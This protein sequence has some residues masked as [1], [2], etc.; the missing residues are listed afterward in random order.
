MRKIK[1]YNGFLL[2]F[3]INLLFNAEWTILAFILLLLH[4]FIKLPL[5]PFFAALGLWIGY[6]FITTLIIYLL[7]RSASS[8]KTPRRQN[9]NPYS[10]TNYPANISQMH[11]PNPKNIEKKRQAENISI[12]RKESEISLPISNVEAGRDAV[13]KIKPDEMKSELARAIMTYPS[14]TKSDS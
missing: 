9:K 8:S 12:R 11:A 13:S 2:S 10:K 14:K 6:V 1:T 5:W 7:S 3:I 4:I